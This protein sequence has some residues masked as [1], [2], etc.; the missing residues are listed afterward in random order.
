MGS[1]LLL[2][3][4]CAAPPRGTA[5]LPQFYQRFLESGNLQAWLQTRRAV[6][7]QW[8]VGSRGARRGSA[9]AGGRLHTRLPSTPEKTRTPRRPSQARAWHEA[10]WEAGGVLHQPGTPHM[11]EVVTVE[12]Y[13]ELEQQ[14][15]QMLELGGPEQVRRLAGFTACARTCACVCG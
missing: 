3:V 14:L 2:T 1:N 7:E 11:G 4:R 5:P 8:Q 15:E 9:A 10:W 12:E 6:A 13:F